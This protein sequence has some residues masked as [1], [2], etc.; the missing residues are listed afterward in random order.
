MC[1]TICISVVVSTL[2]RHRLVA[3]QCRRSWNRNPPSP[4]L[5]SLCPPGPLSTIPA[6]YGPYHSCGS[7]ALLPSSLPSLPWAG[8]HIYSEHEIYSDCFINLLGF[9]LVDG[10]RCGAERSE[11]A[12]A[13]SLDRGG[14][15]SDSRTAPY[16]TTREKGFQNNTIRSSA[17]RHTTA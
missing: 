17:L 10:Q 13:R 15:R 4:F 1:H 3:A 8:C 12:S 6:P 2:A 7:H 11:D 5:M 14:F 16:I 9:H